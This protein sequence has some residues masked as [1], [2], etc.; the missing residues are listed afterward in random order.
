MKCGQGHKVLALFQQMQSEGVQPDPGIFVA[1]LN[2]CA[3]VV[4]LEE[5]FQVEKQISQSSS[6]SD[7][8]AGCSLVDMYMLNVGALR[9]LGGCSIGCL[10]IMSSVGMP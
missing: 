4:A 7:I 3:S 2:A 6:H 9:T 1:M 8:F 10:P 5:G